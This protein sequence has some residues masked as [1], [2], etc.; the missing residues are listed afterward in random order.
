MIIKEVP[1]GVQVVNISGSQDVWLLQ[2]LPGTKGW[3]K[4]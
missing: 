4:T 1:E 3:Q 2:L